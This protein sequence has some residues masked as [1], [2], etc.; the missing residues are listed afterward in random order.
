MIVVWGEKALSE[1]VE[2]TEYIAEDNRSASLT[3]LRKFKE[4]AK[5]IGTF[6]LSGRLV[7]EYNNDNVREVI[8]GNYRLLYIV[9]MDLEIIHGA[10]MLGP[11]ND[12]EDK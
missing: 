1:F 8:V 11:A 2:I 9:L 12:D 4:V 7:P 5:R 6:P 10:R 3:M